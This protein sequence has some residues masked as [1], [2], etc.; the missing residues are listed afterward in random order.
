MALRITAAFLAVGTLAGGGAMALAY[1]LRDGLLL[2]LLLMLMGLPVLALSHFIARHRRRLGRLSWQ[3]VVG[4]VAALA[5]DL[6][7]IQFIATLFLSPRDAFALALMLAFACL[8]VG[9]TAWSLIR[10]ITQDIAEVRDAVV[11]VRAGRRTPEVGLADG[12][13]DELSG[14]A[15]EFNRMT[16]ELRQREAERDASEQARR[17]LVAAVSNDLRTPLG[18]VML[19]AQALREDPGDEE[20]V[21]RYLG[22]MAVNLESLNKLI[23]DLFEFARME[24]GDVAWSIEELALDVLIDETIEGISPIADAHATE[25]RVSVPEDLPRVRA[26]PEKVQRVLFNLIQ[27]AVQHTPEG[28]QISVGAVATN[29]VVEVEVADTGAGIASGEVER[30]FEPLWRGGQAGATRSGDGA[31]LGLPIARSIVE[32]HGGRIFVAATSPNGTRICFTLPRVHASAETA[33]G[34][35]ASI[36]SGDGGRPGGGSADG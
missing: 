16:R 28:G 8:L 17:E 12:G 24:A 21:R 26:N 20:T 33:N 34:N 36:G 23:D 3:F 4:V 19:I 31:G 7:G 29:D 13:E 15:S 27:N 30:V 5:L 32:A 11:A 1:G 35:R 6:I 2:A 9:F 10:D 25:L 14:L 18:A 22:Q